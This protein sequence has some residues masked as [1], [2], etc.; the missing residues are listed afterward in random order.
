MSTHTHTQTQMTESETTPSKFMDQCAFA[1]LDLGVWIF[2][3]VETKPEDLKAFCGYDTHFDEAQGKCVPRET[4]VCDAID[5]S[6]AKGWKEKSK[7]CGSVAGC[8]LNEDWTKCEVLMECHASDRGEGYPSLT[9]Q[10]AANPNC[11]YDGNKILPCHVAIP[12]IDTDTKLKRGCGKEQEKLTI[13]DLC[14]A[15]TVYN[16]DAKQCMLPGNI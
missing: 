4:P 9:D 1:G 12:D 2:K 14:G 13:K 16:E 15:G 10:C 8:S 5:L 7:T 6:G 3:N 11:T